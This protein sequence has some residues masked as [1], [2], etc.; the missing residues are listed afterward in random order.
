MLPSDFVNDDTGLIQFAMKCQQAEK[1]ADARWRSGVHKAVKAWRAF[2]SG[3]FEALCMAA[4]VMLSI[5]L[6]MALGG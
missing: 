3:A 4:I 5:V 2:S 6:T 1:N